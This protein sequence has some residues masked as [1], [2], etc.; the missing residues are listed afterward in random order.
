MTETTMHLP[1]PTST[2]DR[3]TGPLGWLAA[4]WGVG[5]VVLLLGNA[6]A[7]LAPMAVEAI[8]GPLGFLEW[9]S[10]VACVAFMGFFEGY[11]GFQLG[12]S[13]RVVSRAVH[14]ARQP[15]PALVLLAPLFCMGL[16][17][18]SRK[19]LT[20]SW[21]L[22]AGIVGL[23]IAVRQVPQPWRG[24]LDAGVVVGLSWGIVAILAFGL[25]ALA[26]RPPAM[27]VEL[28]RR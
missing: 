14:L 17:H 8:R 5:G 24:I 19:R 27:Q 13:P 3:G 4:I 6:V 12:F 20:V 18:A 1:P 23:V 26:G 11:R 25:R 10:L 15:R 7:R 2:A 9:G 16:V 22:T 28:P 21:I